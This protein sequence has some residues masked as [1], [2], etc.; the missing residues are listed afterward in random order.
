ME[1]SYEHRRVWKRWVLA[2]AVATLLT[3]QT[4]LDIFARSA[5]N[6]FFNATNPVLA[7]LADERFTEALSD[8]PSPF[9]NP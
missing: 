1:R 4:C 9:A 5:I 7:D 3:R 6:G 8:I 2:I